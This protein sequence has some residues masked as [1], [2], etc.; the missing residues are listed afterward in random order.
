MKR[1]RGRQSTPKQSTKRSFNKSTR[2]PENEENEE[3]VEEQVKAGEE[4]EE[5]VEETVDDASEEGVRCALGIQTYTF[6]RARRLFMI[7]FL[8]VLQVRNEKWSPLTK[9]FHSILLQSDANR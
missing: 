7:H 9:R 3:V 8:S 6:Q 2:K 1:T 4:D 5:E